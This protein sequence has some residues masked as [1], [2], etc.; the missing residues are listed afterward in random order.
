MTDSNRE[1]EILKLVTAAMDMAGRAYAPY[2]QYPVGAALIGKSGRVYGGCNVENVSYG[3]TICAERVAVG[4]AVAEGEREFDAIAVVTPT[5]GSPC[6][7]CRQV[8]AEFNPDLAVYIVKPDGTWRETNL[9][10]LL[11]DG[12]DKLT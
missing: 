8:L 12:F 11:P 2:S 1:T 3:L 4:A 7:A 10:E 5:G 6:G 9:R